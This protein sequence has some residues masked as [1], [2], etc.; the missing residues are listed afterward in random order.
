MLLKDLV[1]YIS[2]QE[3]ALNELS[4]LDPKG[5]DCA[6]WTPF[7]DHFW[8]KPLETFLVEEP[9]ERDDKP[10]KAIPIDPPVKRSVINL[11]NVSRSWNMKSRKILV[12]FEY[13]EAEEAAVSANK[14]NT[15][16]FL[17]C[18]Q[19]GIGVFPSPPIACRI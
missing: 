7:R 15:H 4:D 16:V 9:V 17:V 13:K 10:I 12:R 8:G 11:E 2:V 18:G 19:P 5:N 3:T 1:E 14:P 6:E